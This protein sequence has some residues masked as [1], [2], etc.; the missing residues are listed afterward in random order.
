MPPT[1]IPMLPCADIDEIAE[2]MTALGFTVTYKQT[3]PN[4]FVAF[5]GHGFPI[6][7]YGLEGHLPE[8]SHSTC[9]VLVSDTEAMFETLAAGLR[10]RY[11]KLPVTSCPRITR[12]RPRKN[13]GGVS[14]FSLIDPAG[15]EDPARRDASRG[16][17]RSG[18]L[19]SS[20]VPCGAGREDLT[21]GG[22]LDLLIRAVPRRRGAP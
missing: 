20:G 15:G 12:P 6:Q 21:V 14:G 17:V 19:R 7:Y 9:G 13:V 1:V 16:P 11:G 8:Q 3:R 10:A 22:F 4:P 2:F 5:E 18:R